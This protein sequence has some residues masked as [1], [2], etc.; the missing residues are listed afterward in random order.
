M[1]EVAS[2]STARSITL[3]G[4]VAGRALEQ[5]ARLA[6]ADG[7]MR[8]SH[9]DLHRRTDK[10]A[11]ALAARGIGR[12]DRV[13]LLLLDGIAGIE[14]LIACGKIG[15]IT[16]PI[17]WRLAPAEIRFILEA[18]EPRMLFRS[19]CFA[20]LTGEDAG[21]PVF[22]LPDQAAVDS[23]YE[24]LIA[25]A[26][27]AVLPVVAGHDPLFMLF[28][29]GTTGRPKSC[30]QSHEGAVA[31][32][33]AFALR[34]ALTPADRLL[35]T[36]P[37]FHVGGLGHVFAALAA[38]GG[39]VIVPRGASHEQILRLMSDEGCS[40]GSMND[41]L[42]LG[43]CDLQDR[44]RLPLKLRSVTRGA[45]M[46]PASQIH[47]IRDSLGAC[48]IGGYGQTE[49]LGFVLMLDGDAMRD[50]PT[51]L[52]WPLAHVEA[53]VLD[54]AGRPVV[55]ESVGELGLRSPS[56][57]LG[58]WR[59]EDASREA[60]GTGWLR[61]GDLVQRDAEGRFHFEGRSKE[62][63]KTGGENVYPREVEQVL[64][65]HPAIADVA[66]V[67]VPDDRWGEAVKACI[68]VAPDGTLAAADA[69]AWCRQ[70]IAGYKRPRYVEFIDRIPRDHLGKIQRP[71]LRQRAVTADQ[72]VD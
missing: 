35:C 60:M 54:D 11:A 16:L 44:L 25:E 66:I 42:L 12:G 32:G 40:F 7:V 21:V 46:T 19:D 34:L 4:L 24:K 28:T 49:S 69:V 64:L 47:R 72:K 30:L 56:V 33:T 5:G 67:G 22:A 53:A 59:D 52:G 15:A 13:A 6:I 58:Y 71:L 31:L 51:A 2:I 20:D 3:P 70:H 38:G 18:A 36:S 62:L 63:V 61:T 37:L 39:I 48:A 29:S 55:G 50:H 45:S 68:V 57:M 8:I 41:A 14:L 43:L 65:T 9:A 10:L 1:T 26:D 23:D 17:N 27:A